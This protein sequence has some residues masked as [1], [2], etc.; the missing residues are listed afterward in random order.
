MSTV[1]NGNAGLIRS[2]DELPMSRQ[3][4]LVVCIT[5]LLAALDGYDVLAT[6]FVA[7]ALSVEWGIDK[8]TLG[9]LLAS[10]MIGMATGSVVLSPL[11]DMIGR[12]PTVFAGLG[13]MILGSLLSA[14]CQSVPSLAACRVITGM[15]IGVMVPL[16]MSIAAEFSNARQRPF[17]VA[18]TATGFTLGSVA[19]GLIAS[20]LLTHLGWQSVF[21][22]GAI[23]G[24]ILLPLIAIILPESPAFLLGRRPA[25]TLSKVN[26]VLTDLK[27]PPLTEL[28]SVDASARVSFRALFAPQMIRI[29]VC[30]AIICMLLTTT[31][32]FL[33]N[34][35]PQLIADAGFPAST[36]SLVSAI[37]SLV[38]MV[39]ALL[40]GVLANR[41]GPSLV[42]AL[43]MIGFGVFLALFG[44]TPAAL[45]LLI[46]SASACGF[47]LSGATAVF[48]ATMATTFPAQTRVTGIGF[49]VGV[50]RIASV[51]GPSVAGWL[52]AAGLSRGQVSLF[53]AVAPV[54]AGV[55]L[56]ALSTRPIATAREV[57]AHNNRA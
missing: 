29:T 18:I 10:G 6:A 36:G 24:A 13:L 48:S 28:P 38:G 51:L 57:A 17:A 21:I 15:G 1:I 23:A 53:F 45:P 20:V 40:M 26:R 44:F 30:Y 5:I 31:A 39:S 25:N 3:Q 49:V 22:S 37:S 35:L 27:H 56:L 41:F 34:W 32:Y 47:C 19:G 8:S 7:P 2:L 50:G 11:G 9:I 12:R 43:A 14:F 52:F 54:L 16:T 55:L 42:A 46:L 4:I 33:L